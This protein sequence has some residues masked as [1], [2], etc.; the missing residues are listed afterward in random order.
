M[1]APGLAVTQDSEGHD[2]NVHAF[3]ERRVEHLL[4]FVDRL[5]V[6]IQPLHPHRPGPAHLRQRLFAVRR[7]GPPGKQHSRRRFVGT[8]QFGHDGQADLAGTAQQQ[9]APHRVSPQNSR[10]TTCDA[11]RA[12]FAQSSISCE[13]WP[14]W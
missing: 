10:P 3:A 13:A 6:K 5:G 1:I 14:C 9:D 12:A 8:Q 7:G 11:C 4:V 2:R